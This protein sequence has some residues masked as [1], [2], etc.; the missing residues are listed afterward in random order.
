MQLLIFYI[1]CFLIEIYSL[2]HP[3]N[4]K[5]KMSLNVKFRRKNK[6]KEIPNLDLLKWQKFKIN[7]N[8]EAE[9]TEFYIVYSVSLCAIKFLGY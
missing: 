2:S 1:S 4:D 8:Q 7:R 6:K 3:K 5:I 9:C